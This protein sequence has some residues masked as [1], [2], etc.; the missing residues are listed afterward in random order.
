MAQGLSLATKG[1]LCCRIIP[2]LGTAAPMRYEEECPELV[3]K[4]TDI[5]WVQESGIIKIKKSSI[6]NG[7]GE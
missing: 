4:V 7:N 6:I 5:E 1:V 2:A 3:V